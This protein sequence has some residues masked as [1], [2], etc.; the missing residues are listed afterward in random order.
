MHLYIVTHKKFV[1][2]DI[3]GYI[4]IQVGK[5]YTNID[6][7]FLSDD[8]K[9]NIADKNN[10]YCELTALYWM[11]KN[12]NSKPD[13]V[14]G[15]CHYRRYFTSNL[16]SKSSKYYLTDHEVEKELRSVD[17]IL[18]KKVY[19]QT[20]VKEKY[21]L[22]GSGFQ[23]DLK[24]LREIIVERCPEYLQNY[25]DIMEGKEQYFWNMFLCKKK[26]MDDY[27]EWLFGILG[28][29]ESRVDMREYT[30]QQSRIFGFVSERLLNVW[31][32]QKGLEIKEHYI[33]N[34]EQKNWENLKF[35][36]G[37]MLKKRKI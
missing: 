23:K 36:I 2:P 28:E 14:I 17:I 34:N 26:I 37:V 1:C 27:C 8:Q 9:N 30:K 31:V 4:P 16:F 29:L 11:W 10:T 25:D 15:L 21:S 19:L 3:E 24:L 32:K 7:G 5:C 12:D 35:N 20:T 18:P 22:T 33:V 13:D 6:L